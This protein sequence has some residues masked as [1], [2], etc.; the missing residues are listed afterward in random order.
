MIHIF[1][2]T[3]MATLVNLKKG[4]LVLNAPRVITDIA[5]IFIIQKFKKPLAFK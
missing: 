4:W 3:V 1:R 2:K 5:A